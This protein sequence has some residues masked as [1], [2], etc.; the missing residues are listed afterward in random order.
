MVI[1]EEN[2]REKTMTT[3]LPHQIFICYA[4]ANETFA[5]RLTDDLTATGA[6]A[7]IDLRS[8]RPGRHWTRS[9]EQALSVSTMMIVI[10]SPEALQAPYVAAEWQAYLEAYRPVVPV[11]A[12]PCNLPGPLRTRR[13]LDFSRER[14]YPR[15]YHQ[16]VNRLIELGTR[17][18]RVDPVIWSMAEDVFAHR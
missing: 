5:L 16:L 17:L 10:L 1:L 3:S 6:N 2:K 9:I 8:A 12:Q 11:I 18:R 4:P 15:L 13:P 7:W 14:D